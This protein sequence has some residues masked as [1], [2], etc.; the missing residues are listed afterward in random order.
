M[1]VMKAQQD[2]ISVV[3]I[4]TVALGL[5]STAYLWGVPLLKKRAYESIVNRI[6]ESAFNSN[7]QNSL[8]K[9]IEYVAKYG[10][11]QT[12]SLE[13]GG[14]GSFA[15]VNWVWKLYPCADPTVSVCS[16]TSPSCSSENNTIQ[17]SFLSQATNIAAGQ[18]WIPNTCGSSPGLVSEDPSIVCGKAE[19]SGDGFELVYKIWFRELDENPADPN[20]RAYKYVLYAPTG[21]TSS[22]GKTVRISKGD[23]TS[24][25]VNGK[26]L[27][28]TE[29]KIF[30]V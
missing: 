15:D 7:N 28:T 3:M 13:L 4:I 29:I 8:V 9:K 1:I 6:Y 16:C 5:V 18:G 10:G 22:V 14:E 21:V 2:I 24:Q 23:I 19:T 27:I 30:L 26:T 11:E 12:F 25:I 20:T 17:L